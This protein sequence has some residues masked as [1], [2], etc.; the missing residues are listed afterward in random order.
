[1][2]LVKRKP[3]LKLMLDKLRARKGVWLHMDDQAGKI[4]LAPIVAA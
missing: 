3:D 1:M 4:Y 2:S